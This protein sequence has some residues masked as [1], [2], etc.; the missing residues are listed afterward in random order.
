MDNLTTSVLTPDQR[1]Q[2][3]SLFAAALEVLNCLQ[4]DDSSEMNTLT[5]TRNHDG[6]T[7]RW[8]RFTPAYYTAFIAAI[9]MKHESYISVAWLDDWAMR[10]TFG[11]KRL[12]DRI[13]PQAAKRRSN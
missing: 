3:T 6:Y 7:M 11:V 1:Q 9:G 4:I 5:I 13:T 10:V 12:Q 2:T 8:K